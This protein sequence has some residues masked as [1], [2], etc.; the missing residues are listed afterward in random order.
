[1]TFD[2]YLKKRLIFGELNTKLAIAKL[3]QGSSM[4]EKID[5][6]TISRWINGRTTPT[7]EKQLLVMHCLEPRVYPFLKYVSAPSVSRLHRKV[8]DTV[9][10]NIESSY[11]SIIAHSNALTSDLVP[12]LERLTWD[13]LFELVPSFFEATSSYSR[14]LLARKE[15]DVGGV[16]FC[17]LRNGTKIVSHLSVS[18]DVECL[19]MIFEGRCLNIDFGKKQYFSI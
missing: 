4:F 18:S 12:C 15:S 10:D 7:L 2:T 5:P 13:K 16:T 14:M 9:F 11:H 19:K 17:S 3:Q 1:M 6:V 8:Y